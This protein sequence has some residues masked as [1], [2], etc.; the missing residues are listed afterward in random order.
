MNYFDR[1][2]ASVYVMPKRDAEL[3][4]L[5]CVLIASKFVHGIGLDA[6]ESFFEEGHS[7]ADF[8]R[9]ELK[10]LQVLNWQLA[11]PSPHGLVAKLVEMYCAEAADETKKHIQKIAELFIDLTIFEINLLHLTPGRAAG[12]GFLCALRRRGVECDSALSAELCELLGIQREDL[13]ASVQ[14]RLCILASAVAQCSHSGMLTNRTPQHSVGSCSY[15]G[16]RVMLSQA[17]RC[18]GQWMSVD[19]MRACS[20]GFICSDCWRQRVPT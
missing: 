11:V 17:H 10:V 14:A 3:I 1:Y 6:L 12:A 4:T 18:Q 2:L 19:R 9:S 7:A 13:M 8:L 5:T 20:H 15:T 16:A